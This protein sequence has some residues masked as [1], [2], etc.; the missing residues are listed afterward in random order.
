MSN[1]PR[2]NGAG[3]DTSN[4]GLTQPRP[5]RLPGL[6]TESFGSGPNLVMLHG[7]AMHGGVWRDFAVA[8][9]RTYRVTLVDLPGHGLSA[10]TTDF[11][12]TGIVDAVAEVT[13]APAHWLGWS[14]SAL[15]VLALLE[16][17]PERVR[18]LTLV[19]GSPRFV[20]G[21]AW[22]GIDAGALRQM[23]VNL[24]A[25]YSGTLRRFIG[26][27]THG[28][29]DARGLARTL[30]AR[31]AERPSPAAEA[32]RGGLT[33][34]L[35]SDLRPALRR[36]GACPML[37]LLGSHDRLVPQSVAGVLRGET[38]QLETHIIQGAAHLPFLTHPGETLGL[39]ESFLR[40]VPCH[41]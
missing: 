21:P 28:H 7:W 26:L 11:S 8:L 15:L 38:P 34:L 24:N 19:A 5:I 13:P 4:V 22:P 29:E 36:A 1:A 33:L 6:Y 31:L 10:A 14:L 32:L 30:L 2:P 16:R 41:L 25:D 35:E 18:S 27:Q 9:G 37:S 40:R 12:L 20:A 3:R 17:R 23:A 39:L